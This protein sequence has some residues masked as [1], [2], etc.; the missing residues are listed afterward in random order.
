[1]RKLFSRRATST[2]TEFALENL[3][4]RIVLDGT[5]GDASNPVVEINTDFGNIYIELFPDVAPGTVDNFL[6]YVERGDYD[7]SFFHRHVQ[8]FVLQGGGWTYDQD[9]TPRTEHIEQQDPIE[10]EYN[11][12]NLKWTVAMAKIGG[13]PDSAT[14]EWFINLADNSQNLDNQNGGFTVFGEVVGGRDVVEAI[15]DLRIVNLGSGFETLPVTDSFDPQGDEVNNEDLVNLNTVSLVFDPDLSLIADPS[16][17]PSGTANGSNV[18]TVVLE[19]GFDRAIAFKQVGLSGGWTVTDLNLKT[20]QSGNTSTPVTW[21]DS[22]DGLTYAAALSDEGLLL[23]KNTSGTTWT[24]RNL[25][26]EIPNA[27]LITSSLTTFSNINGRA[28]LAGLSDDG[29]LLL[30]RQTGNTSNGEYTWTTN[31]LS[32]SDLLVNN[33]DTTPRWTTP[34][35]SYVTSWNGLNL[36][37][38][39]ADGNIQAVW[40]AP[41]RPGWAAA[42]LSA[43]TGAPPLQGTIAPYLTSWNAINLTGTDSDGNVVVTWWVPSFGSDWVQSNLTDLRNGPQLAA[44][45]IATWVTPWGGTNIL[46]RNINGDIVVYWWAPNLG[47]GQWNISNLSQVIDGAETPTGQVVGFSSPSGVVNIYGAAD[48]GDLIRYWWRVADGWQ[49]ENVSETAVLS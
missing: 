20:D 14:S 40:W 26:S 18:T 21:I 44:G 29:D 5:P 13:D 28:Y 47:P 35:T 3:E 10:N 30:F 39:D 15:T 11:L 34:L 27:G 1:M 49:W 36:V 42:N 22:K 25:N 23:Y 12:S 24:V 16:I 9:R 17:S 38:L 7:A 46:G 6:G 8:G 37:G 41:G 48:D 43:S 32:E 31:N 33:I 19:N 2:E 4:P 45:S